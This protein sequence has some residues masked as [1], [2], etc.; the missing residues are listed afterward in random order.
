MGSLALVV[1]E[2]Q[3]QLSALLLVCQQSSVKSS[4]QLAPQ[5]SG[6]LTRSEETYFHSFL[7]CLYQCHLLIKRHHY[8]SRQAFFV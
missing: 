1:Q 7:S 3:D 4:H 2:M 8:D 6:K 5:V